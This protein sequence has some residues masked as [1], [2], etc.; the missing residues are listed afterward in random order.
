MQQLNIVELIE[1]NPITMLSRT[2]ND[3]LLNK[4]K[5]KQRAVEQTI[6]IQ[7]LVN[8]EYIYFGT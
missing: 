5:E 7:F 6:I 1:K 4:I 3:K 2:Y 8:T